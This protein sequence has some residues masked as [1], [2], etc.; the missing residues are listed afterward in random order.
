M[1]PHI[2]T[3]IHLLNND[4]PVMN[5]A[6]RFPLSPFAA[7]PNPPSTPPGSTLT[8]QTLPRI[9]SADHA[10]EKQIQASYVSDTLRQKPRPPQQTL[11]DHH[12]RTWTLFKNL[13]VMEVARSVQ[14]G[15][16]A[17]KINAVVQVHSS[18]RSNMVSRGPLDGKADVI[19]M[20]N[21]ASSA[22]ANQRNDS[23]KEVDELI[24][25]L[26]HWPDTIRFWIDERPVG[27]P[28]AAKEKVRQG[29]L[30]DAR[31][32]SVIKVCINRGPVT[33]SRSK[34]PPA[35]RESDIYLPPST[36]AA[37]V[38]IYLDPTKKP[39]EQRVPETK[40][41][42]AKKKT[43]FKDSSS[44][45]KSRLRK[46]SIKRSQTSPEKPP[47]KPSQKPQQTASQEIASQ[48][49]V[50]PKYAQQKAA[51]QK[52]TQNQTASKKTIPEQVASKG[53]PRQLTASTSSW[54]PIPERRSSKKV[55][56]RSP[57]SSY[58]PITATASPPSMIVT[59]V[60]A[61]DDPASKPAIQ[62]TQASKLM[63][64][65]LP[66]EFKN[67]VFND[68]SRLM[69]KSDPFGRF[70]NTDF[71]DLSDSEEE[72]DTFPTSPLDGDL[73]TLGEAQRE[74]FYKAGLR[75]QSSVFFEE[76]NLSGQK[77]I[78]LMH[79]ENPEMSQGFIKPSRSRRLK[80]RISDMLHR[81]K[82]H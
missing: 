30:E 31:N 32:C 34:D 76:N 45:E 75:A 23:V 77:K 44:P 49:T 42:G 33:N 7:A 54:V 16:H 51:S 19:Y 1:S 2:V 27:H 66:E 8:S 80:M 79:D 17:N 73:P 26:P 59:T 37:R 50:S 74:K 46:N 81:R 62:G 24:F 47:R 41:S 52:T 18:L 25:L 12:Q 35:S 13:P 68:I 57:L 29:H 67:N 64:G 53:P 70:H 82:I 55:T 72:R 40:E 36:R 65:T 71:P 4:M 60:S 28:D 6:H 10:A 69:T 48:K 11:R 39:Q 3:K 5:C 21:I 63:P 9:T 22:A 43:P 61:A 38:W 78:E 56:A 15:T 58:P 14:R 20:T